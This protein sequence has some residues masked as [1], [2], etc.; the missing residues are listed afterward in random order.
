MFI[1]NSG[2]PGGPIAYTISHYDRPA[3]VIGNS[4]YVAASFL[5]DGILVR[6]II[7]FAASGSVSWRLLIW[8]ITALQASNGM[9]E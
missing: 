7:L 5:A 1:N 8:I 9:E 3:N 6:I 2:F 4:A